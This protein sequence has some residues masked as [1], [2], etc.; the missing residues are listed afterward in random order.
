MVHKLKAGEWVEVRSKEEILATLDEHGRLAG[1]P[2]MPEMFNYCGKRFRVFKRAHK[3][4]DTIGACTGRRMAEAVHLENVRCS[5]EQHGGCQANCM[6]FWK[7]AWLKRPASQRAGGDSDAVAPADQVRSAGSVSCSEQTVVQEAQI[8]PVSGV[9]PVYRCQATELPK[10]T[11]LLPWWHIAQYVEDYSSGNVTLR[12]MIVSGLHSVWYHLS[13]AG[14]GLGPLMRWLYDKV[15][16][17]RGGVPFPWRRGTIPLGQ[18][19]PS[20]SLNLQPG[21]W[22]RVKS[23]KEILATL[24]QANKNRGLF[25]GPEEVPYCGRTLQ[26]RQRVERI[27]DEKTGKMIRLKTPAV[28]LEEAYCQARYCEWRKFCPRAIFTYWREV[29]LERADL[30][31]FASPEAEAVPELREKRLS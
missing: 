24:D 5:G 12:Q 23:Y 4:C 26:V 30:P 20:A 21:D 15:Q 8:Q 6:I 9:E 25:F 11:E 31:A 3:T 13:E 18:K 10:A 22:A 17:L 14:I 7:E 19:T 16:S 1:L 29:W 27:I 2:F 28:I